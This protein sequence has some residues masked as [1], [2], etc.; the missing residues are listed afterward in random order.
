MRVVA[1]EIGFHQAFGHGMR[2]FSGK[3]C[4]PQQL[5]RELHNVR[6]GVSLAVHLHARV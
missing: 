1:K 4:G 6:S 2:R 5:V 3:T